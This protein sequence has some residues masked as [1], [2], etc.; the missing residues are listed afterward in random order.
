MNLEHLKAFQTAVNTYNASNENVRVGFDRSRSGAVPDASRRI[1]PKTASFAAVNNTEVRAAL[2]DAL[3]AAFGVQRLEELPSDVRRVLKIRDFKLSRNGEVK[4]RRPLTMRRI[5]AI[6]DAVRKV[7]VDSTDGKDAKRSIE[8]AFN[9]GL[10]VRGDVESALVRHAIAS[11]RK[12]MTF[13]MPGGGRVEVPLA[14]LK[15]YVNGKA[16]GHLA[17]QVDIIHNEV[18]SDITKGSAIYRH[19]CEGRECVPSGENQRALRHYLAFVAFAAGKGFKSRYLSVPDGDGRLAAFLGGGGSGGVIRLKANE[20]IDRSAGRLLLFSDI[21]CPSAGKELMRQR[22]VDGLY[23]RLKSNPLA[24][25]ILRRKTPG[26]SFTIAQMRANVLAEY[27]RVLTVADEEVLADARFEIGSVDPETQQGAEAISG[28]KAYRKMMEYRSELSAFNGHLSYQRGDL[29]H[30]DE[31]I[32]DEVVLSREEIEKFSAMPSDVGVLSPRNAARPAEA[33]AA[34]R[35]PRG[36]D[37][38]L[39]DYNWRREQIRRCGGGEYLEGVGHL[40]EAI[41]EGMLEG[42][43]MEEFDKPILSEKD[44]P[45]PIAKLIREIDADWL[46]DFAWYRSVRADLC[47]RSAARSAGDKPLRPFWDALRSGECSRNIP[48][49]AAGKIFEI[50]GKCGMSNAP[51]WEHGVLRTTARNPEVREADRAAATAAAS[52]WGFGANGLTKIV[53]YIQD[54]GYDL[55]SVKGDEIEMLSTLA[56]LHDFKLEDVPTFIQRQTGKSPSEITQKDLVRLFRL[57]QANRLN[58]KGAALKGASAEV[59]AVL[60]GDKLP[61]M[62]KAGGQDVTVLLRAMRQLAASGAGAAVNTEFL[63]RPVALRLTKSGSMVFC[64]DGFEFRAGKTPREF[65][66][67]LENDAVSHPDRFGLHLVLKMLPQVR[68]ADESAD[69]VAAS[70][71][72]ELCLR[73]LDGSIGIRPAMFASV[74]TKE[75]YCIAEGVAD[76]RYRLRSG[77]LSRKAIGSMIERSVNPEVLTSNEAAEMCA[78]LQK[79]G[80]EIRVDMN[81]SAPSSAPTRNPA[82]RDVRLVHAL[83]AD[84]VLD[85]NSLDYDRYQKPGA[86]R[87]G[88]IIA[89]MRRHVP[90][91]VRL[92]KNPAL[93]AS[94]PP[95]I[96]EVINTTFGRLLNALTQIEVLRQL[97]DETLARHFEFLLDT[98]GR[99]RLEWSPAIDA[100]LGERPVSAPK[101][102]LLGGFVSTM[103]AVLGFQADRQTMEQLPAFML[104]EPMRM[105]MEMLSNAVPGTEERLER[106]IS[107]VMNRVQEVVSAA[108]RMPQAAGEREHPLW[109]QSFDEIVGNAMS[110]AD[111]GYGKFVQEVLMTYFTASS[112]IEQRQMTASL[113]RYVDAGSSNGA[114]LG[115]LFRG[116]GPLLQKMLQGLPPAVFGEELSEAL[117]DV[118]SNLQPIPDNFVKAG[119]QRIIDRSAGRIHSISVERSLG[120]ASVGQAFLCRMVT[121]EH[122]K[123]EECVVKLLRPTVKT[124]IARERAIFENAARDVP[125][126]SKT[127]Q[128][129]LERILEE[130]DFT[131][132]ATNID[133]GRSVYEQPAYLRQKSLISGGDIETLYLHSLHSMEVHP[134][135]TPTMDCL[136]LKKAPGE[137]YDRYMRTIRDRLEE[138]RRG[139]QM[140]DGGRIEITDATRAASVKR[141][142]AD[143][144]ADMLKRQGFLVDLTKKWVHEGLFGNGFYHGDLHAGNIMSDGAGLTVIDFGN[145][146]HLSDFERSHV[147]R[148]ISAALVGWHETF[149]SSFTALLSPEGREEYRR[150]NGDG[151]ITRDLA[152]ILHKGTRQDVGMRISAVLMVL[153][154]HGIEVPSSIYNFNQCQ[155]RLGAT[156]DEMNSLME[157]VRSTMARLSFAKFDGDPSDDNSIMATFVKP[158]NAFINALFGGPAADMPAAAGHCGILKVYCGWRADTQTWDF[159][160]SPMMDNFCKEIA[161]DVKFKEAYVPLIARLRNVRRV[162]A[163]GAVAENGGA[164]QKLGNVFD[165]YLRKEK[166]TLSDRRELAESIFMATRELIDTAYDFT[167]ME[168]EGQP[169][170][171]LMAVGDGISDSLYTVRTT[172]GNLTSV[173]LMRAQEAEI[174]KSDATASRVSRSDELVREYVRQN[175]ELRITQENLAKI[176]EAAGRLALPYDLPG[177]DGKG[178]WLQS[179]EERRKFYAVMQVVIQRLFDDLRGQGVVGE[180]TNAM[181]RMH[182]TRIAMQYLVDRDDGL[183]NALR[184]LTERQRQTISAEARDF[185]RDGAADD[186]DHQALDAARMMNQCLIAAIHFVAEGGVR[187][188]GGNVNAEM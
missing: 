113:I 143:L 129:Q 22:D 102:S 151:R 13:S 59:A 67:I 25:D 87:D 74:S 92:V 36:E 173:E 48:E 76:G 8:N 72:R 98:V 73:F 88:R 18:Q 38:R 65:T 78:A 93:A 112:P 120:A 41:R 50:I 154:R 31:R 77:K 1:E 176:K 127:F 178:A 146:T 46:A 45:H 169:V 4:S 107:E 182:Y 165:A 84:C 149:E 130:L 89:V 97:P 69:P 96:A 145:A 103:S 141:E 40:I 24:S 99:P 118:K 68:G 161:D 100:Y 121:D 174:R 124:A 147:L 16:G 164:G 162:D 128:G 187:T 144:Y 137:T 71:S 150:K 126:M 79:L 90:A 177:R 6:L 58:D 85:F 186:G 179:E 95:A 152:D 27:Q 156:V 29:D 52:I 138:I 131:L 30:P 135:A 14:W 134:L 188:E 86:D 37:L 17:S 32:A 57:K 62:T 42:V 66:E 184:G 170:S 53:R 114:I 61:S 116:A 56:A 15:A 119:M 82:D 166:P 2:K 11:G 181:R 64:L 80:D 60:K 155:M 21:D 183:L 10:D 33:A 148:M 117:R 23:Q 163:K 168:A 104:K 175:E 142:L 110:D 7:A 185:F 157:E 5:R 132:E 83:M 81:R 108:L 158:L 172:L 39:G 101:K 44:I 26:G 54:C 106:G 63:G 3:T 133:F 55:K 159:G 125:G 35:P 9:G 105:A 70:R 49:A 109:A 47:D 171:F 160:S 136:V 91:L 167:K 111:G 123:G 19:L 51:D 94:F 140:R 20:S 153:Q 180:R 75:L 122:P 34:A 139:A 43:E 28:T 115:A 12:P